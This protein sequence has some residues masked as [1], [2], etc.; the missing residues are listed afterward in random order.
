MDAKEVSD[1]AL[2]IEQEERN[3]LQLKK[4]LDDASSAYNSARV[5]LSNLRTKFTRQVLPQIDWSI[6]HNPHPPKEVE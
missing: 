1:I 6:A 2:A 4:A 3:V 5:R